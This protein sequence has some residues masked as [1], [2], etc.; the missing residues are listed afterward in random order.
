MQCWAEIQTYHLPD[1]K[2]T[3]HGCWAT[4]AWVTIPAGNFHENDYNKEIS[5]V[6][7]VGE[8]IQKIWVSSN[9]GNMF[10]FFS[11]EAV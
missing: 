9:F 2:L 8:G 11:Y 5:W 1:D 4:I 3:R 10:D 6:S 7:W